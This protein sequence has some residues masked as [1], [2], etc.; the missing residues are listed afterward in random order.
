MNV[1][2][3]ARQRYQQ[4]LQ[5][6][7]T[8]VFGSILSA[9]V[10]LLLLGA[11]FWTGLTPFPFDPGFSAP[12]KP[13]STPCPTGTKPVDPKTITAQVYNSTTRTGL[14]GTAAKNLQ[15]NGVTVTESSNWSGRALEPSATIFAGAGGIDSAY[16]LR[17]FFPGSTVQF[18]ATQTNDSVYVVLGTD[19]KDMV[20][21]PT[22]EQYAAAMQPIEGCQAVKSVG[23][24]K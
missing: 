22:A 24:S 20:A 16:T 2:I 9:M 8:V 14:A 6:R 3:S 5:R 12:A 10:A 23:D 13:I 18:D 19:E 4:Q 1:E 11:V 15:A 21:K 17:A 7:Q